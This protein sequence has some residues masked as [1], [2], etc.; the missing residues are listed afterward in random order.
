MTAALLADL[1]D[2]EEAA[3]AAAEEEETAPCSLTV[4]SADLRSVPR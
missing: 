1:A 4:V 3:V 2:D